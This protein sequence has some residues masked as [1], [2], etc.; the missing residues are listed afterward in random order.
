MVTRDVPEGRNRLRESGADEDRCGQQAGEFTATR[1]SPP[2]PNTTLASDGQSD[3]HLFVAESHLIANRWE[4][5]YP[6][7]ERWEIGTGFR[8]I[9]VESGLGNAIV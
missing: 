9:A 7:Q 2:L 8:V 3:R 4:Y 1:Q 5:G 6:T